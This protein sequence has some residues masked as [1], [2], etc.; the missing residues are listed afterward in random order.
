MNERISEILEAEAEAAEAGRDEP[1]PPA[2]RVR[3]SADKAEVFSVRIPKSGLDEL[4]QLAREQH[5]TPGALIR[6]WVLERLEGRPAANGIDLDA[7]RQVVR[8]E[9]AA[10]K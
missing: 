3:S 6:A 10:S 1:F 8:E 4:R 5:T 9:L 7:V 2:H